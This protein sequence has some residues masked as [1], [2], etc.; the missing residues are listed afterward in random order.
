MQRWSSNRREQ[1]TSN[2]RRKTDTESS[3][4][5][6][7]DNFEHCQR[8]VQRMQGEEK[9]ITDYV[10]TDASSANTIKEMKIDEEKQHGLSKLEEN[11]ATN[12]N[13][14]IY[15]DH[16]SILINLDFEIPTEEQRPKKII[17]KKKDIKD[18]EQS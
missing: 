14:K 10:L 3:K 2:Q 6:K 15:S 12:E 1:Y 16:N 18:T 17:T 4:K 11:T 8:K 5:R 13:E 7:H 9:S